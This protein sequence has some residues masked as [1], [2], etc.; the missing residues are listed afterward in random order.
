[1]EQKIFLTFQLYKKAHEAKQEKVIP[2]IWYLNHHLAHPWIIS[3]CF[4]GST[5]KGILDT[6]TG[7]PYHWNKKI[8][9]KKAEMK[10]RTVTAPVKYA[11]AWAFTLG[12]T[13]GR[14]NLTAWLANTPKFKPNCKDLLHLQKSEM[15]YDIINT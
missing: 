15:M 11:Y 4:I 6:M 5:K 10:S 7:Q 14:Q 1:M 9:K 13:P 2:L 12:C 3:S 8:S